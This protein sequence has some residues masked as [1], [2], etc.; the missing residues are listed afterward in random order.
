MIRLIHKYNRSVAIVFL[1]IAFC[2]A[3]S[4]V[5]ID[6]L[7]DGN[8]AE[9]PAVLV[10][11]KSFTEAEVARTVNK[12]QSAYRRMYGDNFDQYAKMFGIN[13][14]QQSVDQMI[15]A[16]LLNQ[17]AAGM[18]FSADDED[19]RRFILEKEFDGT[20][21]DE[22][23]FRAMLKAVNLNYRDYAKDVKEG[24]SRE[25]LLGVIRDSAYVSRR[26]IQD[27]L[28]R[29]ETAYLV[30]AATVSAAD[31][32]ASAPQPTE[33]QL[34]AFYDQNA[35]RFEVPPSASYTFIELAPSSFEKDVQVSED[36]IGIYYTENLKDFS[37]P[38]Q[39]RI[40]E[41]RVLYPKNADDKA[42]AETREKVKQAREEALAGKAFAELVAKYT[43]DAALK[44]SGGDRGWVTRG[45]AAN[46]AFD[47][48]A[49]TT[50]A[51][52]VSEIIETEESISILKVEEK[53]PSSAKPLP[54]VRA[55]IESA[56]RKSEAPSYAKVKA[57]ELLKTARRDN[58]PL[59]E[60]AGLSGMQ[61]KE[62]SSML[63][64]GKDPSESL[65]GLTEKVLAL[66]AGE[67]LSVSLIEVG[68]SSALVQ[69]KEFK[70]ASLAPFSE[71]RARILEVLKAQEAQKLAE[72]RA[73]ELV[74]AAQAAPQAF[75]AEAKKLG[76]K[77]VSGVKVSRAQPTSPEIP[78]LS[79]PMLKAIFSTKT[80]QVI[81][82]PF[83]SQTGF[84]VLAVT[85]VE[86]PDIAKGLKP[87]DLEK[88]TS[89]AREE[90]ARNALESALAYLKSS[91]KIDVAPAI[92][93]RQ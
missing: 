63:A 58:K 39:V 29:Q 87:E 78:D 40:R 81:A 36:D 20:P 23:R 32:A 28:V 9:R 54:A 50:E 7:H 90:A 59:S 64:A 91:S 21:F 83:P 67:R 79:Q 30:Q 73:Q 46:P 68:D 93:A 13:L 8:R 75:A 22:T 25:A 53:K 52:G 42:K 12:L 17:E 35:A 86:T 80:P 4:G 31:L 88:Y 41:I 27:Q 69:V 34:K 26:D 60:V 16:A 44:A 3:M 19:V 77:V 55:Q 89:Q 61:L 71:V 48:A 38:E 47:R 6:V 15:D 45:S 14:V 33:E 56:I 66:P 5:G 85:G 72:T 57:E 62:S 43:T 11:D 84:V 74:T 2:F 65:S 49:F 92:L 82:R 37:D 1:F 18:G 24:E 10:N 51:G 76:A 70:D